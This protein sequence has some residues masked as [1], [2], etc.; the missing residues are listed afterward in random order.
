VGLPTKTDAAG[1]AVARFGVQLC[2]IDEGG[3]VVILRS[4]RKR[5]VCRTDLRA[6]LATA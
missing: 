1:P 5:P 4:G 3:H 2:E 6:Q